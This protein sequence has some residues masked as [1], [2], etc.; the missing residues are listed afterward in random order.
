MDEEKKDFI[1]EALDHIRKMPETTRAM[2]A[3]NPDVVAGRI[4]VEEQLQE[5][6]FVLYNNVIKAVTEYFEIPT[7][8][9]IFRGLGPVIGETHAANLMYAM[10]VGMTH[11]S[12]QTILFYDDMLKKEIGTQFDEIIKACNENRADAQSTLVA[13][14]I[15]RTQLGKITSKESVENFVKGH[16]LAVKPD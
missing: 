12:H 7:V 6:G 10:A 5:P 8:Q 4:T 1:E 11:T 2:A 9:A 16:N 3:K 13:V 15:I 14:D